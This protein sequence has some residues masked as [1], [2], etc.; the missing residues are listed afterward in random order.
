[1]RALLHPLAAI[2]PLVALLTWL[3]VRSVGP[4]GADYVSAQRDVARVSSAEAQLQG[5]VLRARAGLLRDDDPIVAD[6]AELERAAAELRGQAMVP[7]V[8]RGL[9]VVLQRLV[10]RDAAALERFKTDNALLQNSLAY[11]DLLDTQLAADDV[12]PALA[13]AI[14]ALGNA[15][16]HLT[17][18]PSAPVQDAV[19]E[20]LDAVTGLGGASAP[21]RGEVRLLAVHGGLLARLLP[22]VDEDL[23]ALFA[24]STYDLRQAIRRGQDARRMAEEGRAA[25]YRLALYGVALLL[26]ALLARAGLA[27]RAAVR[28]QRERAEVE[29]V[30]AG[31]STRFLATPF[32]R[33]DEMFAPML[34]QLGEA[35]GAERAYLLLP[36]APADARCWTGSAAP[37]PAGWPAGVLAP[38]LA[39]CGLDDLLDLPQTSRLA[40]GP[41]RDALSGAGVSGWCGFVLRADAR[42]VGLLA[43]ERVTAHAPS[44]PRGGAGAVRMAGEVVSH[45]VQRLL[46][47]RKRAELEARLARAGRLEAVGSFASGIAHNFNNL[48][49]AVLGHAE[50]ATDAAPPEG[51]PAYHLHEI[52]RAGARAQ[53]LVGRILAFGTRPGARFRPLA[54]EALLEEVCAV[55]RVLL[56]EGVELVAEPPDASL[57]VHGD[58]VQLQQVFVNLGRNAVEAMRDV[59]RITVRADR[60][61]SDAPAT[62]SRGTIGAGEHVRIRVSDTGSGMDAATMER[63]FQPFFTARAGGTGLG[64]ATVREI[65]HEHGG[66]ID[67]SSMP[68]RGSEFAVWLPAV[69]AGAAAG[70]TPRLGAG[71]TVLVLTPDPE[72]VLQDEEMLAALSYEPVGFREPEAAL[73]AVR[74]SPGRFDAVLLDVGRPD[75]AALGIL[76]GLRAAL[77]G[78]PVLLALRGGLDAGAG[79]LAA[80]G[81]AAALSRPLRSAALAD[82]LATALAG[83]PGVEVGAGPRRAGDGT[84]RY[85]ASTGSAK[86]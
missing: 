51:L 26:A 74:A 57:C 11:F 49:A 38:A 41:L 42:E 48:I 40:P 80:P 72:Q 60:R 46:T 4:Q 16:L 64:L 25:R 50:M 2:L 65:V 36:H 73:E 68:G 62:L 6:M 86:E 1:M 37:L 83:G 56:P 21:H 29:R 27:R 81:V 58:A 39:A 7:E 24:I 79:E 33:L 70:P 77:P 52:R 71:Q 63:I 23:R 34:R 47:A 14:R 13:A 59:G 9:P 45:A 85:A 17:R 10:E 35:F 22:A 76:A 84:A 15:V 19:R 44:W 53:E 5:D 55:L 75:R 3:S 8:D 82:A 69:P 32:E 61:W 18:D 31:L 28:A 30:V 78:R 43:F 66:A 20:R 54:V 12:P 67:V